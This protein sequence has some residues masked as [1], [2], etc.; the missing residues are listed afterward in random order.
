[1][2]GPLAEIGDTP[3]SLGPAT[4]AQLLSRVQLAHPDY[5]TSVV[6]A[7]YDYAE[8]MHEPQRRASGDPYFIQ[9]VRVAL[10]L[11]EK[12]LDPATIATA[13]LHDVVEDTGATNKDICKMFG[14]TVGDIE[15][16]VHPT[17]VSCGVERWC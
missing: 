11:A 12:K 8:T 6:A 7:A 16:D 14:G 13:L 4:R 1:M 10:Y 17:I 9:P 3:Q 2:P 15:D 5:D